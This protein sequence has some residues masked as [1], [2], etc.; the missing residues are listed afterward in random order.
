MGRILRALGVGVEIASPPVK[1]DVPE[2]EASFMGNAL[3]KARA[4]SAAL[5]APALADD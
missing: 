4:Y 2:T 1:V 5:D 3:L